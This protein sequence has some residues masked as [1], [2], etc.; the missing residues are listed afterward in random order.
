[1]KS[2]EY[3]EKNLKSCQREKRDH[4]KG[5]TT[6]PAVI[7]EQVTS[8]CSEK[9]TVHVELDI[10]LNYVFKNK[11]EMRTFSENPKLKELSPKDAH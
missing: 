5:I 8:D 3:K 2:T 9:T 4:L 11:G 7:L 1:M 6:R 10:Y